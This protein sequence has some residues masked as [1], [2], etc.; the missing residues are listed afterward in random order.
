MKILSQSVV[1]MAGAISQV[2]PLPAP[3]IGTSQFLSSLVVLNLGGTNAYVTT[4]GI[5]IAATSG[6]TLVAAGSTVIVSPNMGDQYIAFISASST[7]T[8]LAIA[9]GV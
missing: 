6:S 3:N 8:A 5:G 1:V 7:P 9:R 2:A 4:G